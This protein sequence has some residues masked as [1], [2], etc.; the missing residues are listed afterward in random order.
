MLRAKPDVVDRIM[1]LIVAILVD[2]YAASVIPT[3]RIK[4]HGPSKTA[5]SY[6]ETDGIK[7]VLMVSRR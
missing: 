5:A 6:L 4:A 3:V 1:R 7:Q 2:V